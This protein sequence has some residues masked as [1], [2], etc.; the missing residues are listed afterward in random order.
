MG[1]GKSVKLFFALSNALMDAGIAAW[2]C[3]R[4]FDY[5]RP[6]TVIRHLFKD[7]AVQAWGGPGLGTVTMYGRDWMPYQKADFITPPFPEFVS[8]HS[9]FSRAAAE[10][11]KKFTGSDW[12]GHTATVKGLSI[13]NVPDLLPSVDLHWRTFTEAANEAGMSRRYGGIHFEQGDLQGRAIGAKVAELVWK[14][15]SAYWEGRF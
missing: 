1:I 10:I 8:G 3:K 13:D 5:A 6:V 12:F 2:D 15:A 11:L 7:K 14:K 9:T 4:A